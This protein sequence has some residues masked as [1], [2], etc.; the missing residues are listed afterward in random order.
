MLA[1]GGG[2]DGLIGGAENCKTAFRKRAQMRAKSGPNN[3]PEMVLAGPEIGPETVPFSG[4]QNG[5][6][7]RHPNLK[8]KKVVQNLVRFLGPLSVLI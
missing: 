8:Y 7:K 2:G 5:V 3:R 6:R 1:R 4:T